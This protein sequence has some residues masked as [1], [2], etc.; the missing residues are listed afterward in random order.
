MVISASCDQ[1]VASCQQLLRHSLGI[2]QDLAL[3]GNELWRVHLLHVSSDR[4][5]LL[6]VGS[7]LKAG[8]DSIVNLLRDVAVILSGED[9]TG[10]RSL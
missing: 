6:I 9:H 8:E 2:G 4:T 1:S 5:N 7:T 3:V 10:T